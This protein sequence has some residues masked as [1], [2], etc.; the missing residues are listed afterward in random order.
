[1]NRFRDPQSSGA[2][3]P[4]YHSLFGSSAWITLKN[5]SPLLN[6]GDLVSIFS[7]FGVVV[8]VVIPR[9]APHKAKES[10]IA[11]TTSA[12]EGEIAGGATVGHK[13]NRDDHHHHPASD[14]TLP[15]RNTSY[16]IEFELVGSAIAAADC[17][18]SCPPIHTLPAAQQKQLKAQL[19]A[20]QGGTASL[21]RPLGGRHPSATSS[22]AAVPEIQ[23]AHHN[24]AG[25]YRTILLPEH[26][27]VG[28]VVDRCTVK[29]VPTHDKVSSQAALVPLLSTMGGTGGA[30]GGVAGGAAATGP[31]HQTGG[32]GAGGWASGGRGSPSK[33]AYP[34][35]PEWTLAQLAARQRK[36]RA[37]VVVPPQI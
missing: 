21:L 25:P 16:F 35:F 27:T 18:N 23:S 1:M 19:Q 28:L 26:D 8:D 2:Y 5:V 6:E 9:T 36:M 11:L 34:T 12:G 30:T 7:Q 31:H 37:S 32:G 13:R 17:M 20:S 24:L 4:E 33:P 15:Q 3:T 29:E 22:S 10:N 14:L